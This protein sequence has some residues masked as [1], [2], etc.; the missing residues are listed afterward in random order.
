MKTPSIA[1]WLAALLAVCPAASAVNFQ[2]L[3]NSDRKLTVLAH[4]YAGLQDGAAFELQTLTAVL[5]SRV[6]IRVEWVWC[7]AGRRNERSALCGETSTRGH[8][9]IRILPGH[10][11]HENRL[12]PALGAAVVSD[13]YAVLY[14]MQIRQFAGNNGLSLGC[15]MAYATAHE[16]G[17]LL[18]GERHSV[19]GIMRAVWGKSEFIGMAQG[20]LTFCP[21]ECEKI[22]R[23][24]PG[25]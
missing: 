16:I 3:E 2:P 20:C 18:L 22:R 24:V 4:D 25:N 7:T 8:I 13:G 5:F 21:S 9:V 19:S 11:G 10:P 17:H 1:I 6:G 12:V 23:A 14:G 15:L